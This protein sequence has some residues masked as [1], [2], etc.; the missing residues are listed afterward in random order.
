MDRGTSAIS[1]FKLE[2]LGSDIRYSYSCTSALSPVSCTR[3]ILSASSIHGNGA[4]YLDRQNVACPTGMYLAKTR[5]D[6]KNTG[7]STSDW[8][9]WYEST[10]CWYQ[11]ATRPRISYGASIPTT[12]AGLSTLKASCLS[13]EAISGFTFDY[14]AASYNVSC[15]GDPRLSADRQFYTSWTTSTNSIFSLASHVLDCGTSALNSFQL[16]AE[17]DKIRYVYS[18]TK[19]STLPTQFTST[20]ASI[21][22]YTGNATNSLDTIYAACPSEYLLTK[23]QLQMS[24]LGSHTYSPYYQITC[25]RRP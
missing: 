8:P 4:I 19:P 3:G 22:G 7:T 5:L 16:E 17:G 1:S 18:C 2:A 12:I 10:C 6:Y 15:V 23:L 9:I 25:C 24:S 21:T 20:A 13:G 14:Y 11:Y